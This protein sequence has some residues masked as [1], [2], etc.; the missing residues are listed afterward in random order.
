VYGII[1]IS[2]ELPIAQRNQGALAANSRAR[3]AVMGRVDLESRRLARDVA[4]ARSAYQGRRRELELLTGTAL[5]AATRSLSFAE[6]AWQAGRF[7]VFRVLA[8]ARDAVRVRAL[9]VEALEQAWIARIE[10]E[11]AAGGS[12]Q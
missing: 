12:V 5:P 10:L 1:G 2:V 4:A 7:D 8:A 11:R 3:E 9:R 6:A